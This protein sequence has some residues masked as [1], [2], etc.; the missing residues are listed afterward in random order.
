VRESEVAPGLWVG[1]AEIQ[2][3]Y[4]R[5]HGM[6]DR[7]Y[8]STAARQFQLSLERLDENGEPRSG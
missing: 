8:T 1:L 2:E 7:S 5:A 4:R 3:R 6:L